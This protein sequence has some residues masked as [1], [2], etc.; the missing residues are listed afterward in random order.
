MFRSLAKLFRSIGYLF[1]GKIDGKRR[2]ISANPAAVRA[3][4]DRVIREK[5]ARMQEYKEAV[6]RLITQEQ[7]KTANI[8]NLSQEVERLEQLKAGAAAKARSMVDSARA[9]GLSAEAI[10][11]EPDYQQCMS[12]YNDFNSTLKEKTQRIE[13]LEA[14]VAELEGGINGHKVQLQQLLREIEQIKDES[15]QTVADIITS[16]EEEEL[17]DILTGIGTDR[18]SEELQELREMRDQ[19]R[20][21]ATVS[22]ELAGTD[23]AAQEREF[24]E[25]ARTHQSNDEF[26]QLIGLAEE[27]HVDPLGSDSAQPDRDAPGR[28]PEQ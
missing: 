13:A 16:K 22:K 11:Q 4:Y 25:F 27:Q 26:D 17:A 3:T 9:R 6:A 2:Q 21:R 5:K 1:S 20:A 24:L 18:T 12:A 14:D 28:L 8:R 19:A 15:S 23:A 10:R 7:K